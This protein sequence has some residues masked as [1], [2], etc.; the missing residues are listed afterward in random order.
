[1]KR[2]FRDALRDSLLALGE[3]F[4]SMVVVTADVGKS[5]RIMDFKA[6]YPD[7]FIS[8]GISEADMV[9]LASGL[10]LVGL[11]PVVADF[12]MFAVEKPFEQIRN[13]IAYP[14]LNVKIVGTHS[15]VNVGKDGATH[16]AI[17][18]MAIM[19]SLPGFTV[20]VAADFIETGAAL[21]AAMRHDGPVYLRLGRDDAEDVYTDEKRFVIGKADSI[22]TGEDLTIIACGVMV[23]EALQAVEILEREGIGARLINMHSIKPIDEDAIV[24]AACE[25]G[26]IVTVEDHSRIGGLGGAVAEV[27][28][29]R[30]P[31]PMEQ[32]AIDDRFGE[33]GSSVDLFHQ[34]GLS[35]DQIVE[36]SKRI[37]KRKG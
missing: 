23:A 33:S 32:V 13:A 21:R 4:P 3:E 10:S 27:L 12:A 6:A 11:V 28:V 37:L 29:Q 7:R 22:R 35:A 19:R 16:Q 30:S 20:L 9:S 34:Y 18:D 31:V 17:E 15:G 8:V 36:K 26:G 2:S 14:G 25:T 1:M 5:L 24:H